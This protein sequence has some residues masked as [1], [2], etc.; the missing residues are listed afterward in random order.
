M[1]VFWAI[2]LP[3][4]L[5]N[6]VVRSF[7]NLSVDDGGGFHDMLSLGWVMDSESLFLG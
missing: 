2:G 1:G 5:R 3:V 4:C 6:L 7:E